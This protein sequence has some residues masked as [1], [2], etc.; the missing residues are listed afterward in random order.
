MTVLL[1]V[2]GLGSIGGF[3]GALF[4]GMKWF[5]ARSVQV[6]IAVGRPL[7]SL[8]P[9]IRRIPGSLFAGL[10]GP[11]ALPGFLAGVVV[12]AG[13]YLS[14]FAAAVGTWERLGILVLTS[15]LATNTVTLLLRGI[16]RRFLDRSQRNGDE[17]DGDPG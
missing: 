3:C 14:G 11:G 10:S 16:A 6:V 17:N 8:W 7:A 15:G 5:A 12:F 1:I 2:F 4:Y 13:L 9:L